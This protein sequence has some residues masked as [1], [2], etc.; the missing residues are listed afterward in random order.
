[1]LTSAMKRIL[2]MISALK[3]ILK[4]L[5]I[6]T[7][8]RVILHHLKEKGGAVA[9]EEAAVAVEVAVKMQHRKEKGGAVTVEEAAVAV[10]V[11]VKVAV[12]V[13]VEG[14]PMGN[15]ISQFT[16]TLKI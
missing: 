2:M 11:A 1:M 3:K 15:T 16:I 9:V 6:L 7:I 12:E 10:E 13:A 5:K 8:M 4:M 14:P